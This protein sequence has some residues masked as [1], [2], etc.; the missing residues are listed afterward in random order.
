MKEE[1]YGPIHFTEK[2][3]INKQMPMDHITHLKTFNV[4]FC[5]FGVYHPTQEFEY[6]A[7]TGEGLQ[8]LTYMYIYWAKVKVL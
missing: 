6:V 3:F 1:A 7:I 4:K 2:K 8:I 5:L